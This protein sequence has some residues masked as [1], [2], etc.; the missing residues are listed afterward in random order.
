[1]PLYEPADDAV[2]MAGKCLVSL[3]NGVPVSL[4]GYGGFLTVGFDHPVLNLP[5]QKDFAL[6]GNAFDGSAEP[7]I[8]LVSSDTNGDGIPND[9]WYELAGSESANPA[10]LYGYEISYTRPSGIEAGVPWTDNQGR[11]GTIEY[12]GGEKGPHSHPH[13]PEWIAGNTLTF[14]G[15]CL[16]ENGKWDKEKKMWVMKPYAYGYADNYPNSN[17]DGCSFDIGW[18]IGE[19]GQPVILESIDF[20]RIY[21]G[22]NQQIPSGGVGELSTEITGVEDLHPQAAD[23]SVNASPERSA[24]FYS[25]GKLYTKNTGTGEILIYDWKGSVV[26]RICTNGFSGSYPVD[27]QPGVYLVRCPEGV[28]KLGI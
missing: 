3:Q 21:T 25:D 1:M 11:R 17:R 23:I 28:Y 22:V 7:G 9:E 26:R 16:P 10:T 19:N 12:M 20:I 18:A 27:L 6:W 2:T 4:G 15:T 13:Y 24:L 14:R 8:V 5:G